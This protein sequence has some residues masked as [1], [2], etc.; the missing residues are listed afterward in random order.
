MVLG[1][2]PQTAPERNA[3]CQQLYPAFSP[4]AVLGYAKVERV[5]RVGVWVVGCV[6]VWCVGVCG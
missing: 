5:C 4:V 3:A 1:P 2:P 6:C